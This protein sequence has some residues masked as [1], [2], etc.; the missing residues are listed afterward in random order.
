MSEIK[1]I[2]LRI[3]KIDD[4]LCKRADNNLKRIGI[5][6]AQHHT[7]IYLIHQENHEAPLKQ[8]ESHFRVSQATM[9]GI[10]KRMEERG[11]IT[12]FTSPTDKRIKLVKLTSKAEDICKQTKI[13]M[14]ENE[15]KMRS[16]YTD[17]EL[18]LFDEFLNRLF[19]ELD[20]EKIEC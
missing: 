16:L 11:L 15:Q 4:L 1:D 12:S 19:K 5:T 7:M 17:E 13:Y 3:K 14:Q 18:V 9:A 20:T 2:G 10:I 8:L 6:F